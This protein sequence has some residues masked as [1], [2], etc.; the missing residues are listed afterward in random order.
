[1]KIKI[2]EHVESSNKT[3][4]FRNETRIYVAV[5]YKESLEIDPF[6]DTKECKIRRWL[7][8]SLIL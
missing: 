2:Y 4:K 1:M 3:L 7:F 8:T 6:Y 5:R